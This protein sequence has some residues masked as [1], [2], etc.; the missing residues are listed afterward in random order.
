MDIKAIIAEDLSPAARSAALATAAREALAGAEKIDADALGYTPA[1]STKVDGL[2]GA[3][4][5]KVRPNGTIEYG[6][7]LLPDVFGWIYD[8]LVANSPVGSGNDPHI[9]Q[10]KA[11]HAL[12]A[13]GVQ[14]DPHEKIPVADEYVFVNLTEYSRRIE[15]GDSSQAVN[16]VYEAV[17]TLA[18]LKFGDMAAIKFSYRAPFEGTIIAYVPLGRS[19]AKDHG[20]LSNKRGRFAASKVDSSLR[21]IADIERSL[22]L[23]AITIRV[24]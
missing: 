24:R 21:T 6:F 19:R 23:P 13:D 16:G 8:Q 12:F 20:D 18:D 1:H 22:R 5:S 11:S 4:E 3:D 14:I 2:V 15:D 17:A 7:N 9:G 10:Y